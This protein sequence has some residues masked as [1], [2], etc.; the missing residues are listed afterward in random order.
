MPPLMENLQELMDSPP[1]FCTPMTPP[2][3]RMGGYRSRWLKSKQLLNRGDSPL[4][5]R[6]ILNETSFDYFDYLNKKA[7]GQELPVKD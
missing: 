5:P 6:Q 2:H 7:S 4:K 3:V 1:L